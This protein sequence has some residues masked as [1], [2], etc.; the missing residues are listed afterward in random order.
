MLP[1]IEKPS[2]KTKA[3]SQQLSLNQAIE[4]AKRLRSKRRLLTVLLSVSILM[5]FSFWIYRTLKPIFNGSFHPQIN[6]NFSLPSVGSFN[7]GLQALL[8]QNKNIQAVF[9][10]QNNPQK[11]ISYGS[12]T[13]LNVDS[14]G[15]KLVKE[16]FSPQ[17]ANASLLPLGLKYQ[18]NV[19]NN[20]DSSF[21]AALISNP[22]RNVYVLI[23]VNG[24]LDPVQ[25]II[26]NIIASAYWS[27]A[28]SN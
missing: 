26:P 15:A 16:P 23:Q 12:F 21:V 28:G 5:C 20:N 10:R 18:E 6:L 9:V 24:S 11:Q 4:D 13:N 1:K 14:L 8:A 7:S 19:Q 27:I 22:N 25:N 2:R 3:E 17:S